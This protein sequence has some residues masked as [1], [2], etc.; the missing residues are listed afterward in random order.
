MLSV[1]SLA[2]LQTHSLL[3]KSVAT[4]ALCALLILDER[5]WPVPSGGERG[6][7]GDLH[8]ES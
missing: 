4:V 7:F 5:H 3:R 2:A 6:G 1:Q 8:N